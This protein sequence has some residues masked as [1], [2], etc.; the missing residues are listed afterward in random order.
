MAKY[1]VQVPGPKLANC[2]ENGLSPMLPPHQLAKMGFTIAAYPLS[3]LAVRDSL[4][5][6]FDRTRERKSVAKK[7]C[8]MAVLFSI[9]LLFF[10]EISLKSSQYP[11]N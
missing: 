4:R 11:F 2:L 10:F 3:L 7:Y 8:T 6:V 5:V 9:L 1:C